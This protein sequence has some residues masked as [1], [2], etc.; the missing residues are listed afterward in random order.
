MDFSVVFGLFQAL[1]ENP[2]QEMNIQNSH[3]GWML[4]LSLT[5]SKAKL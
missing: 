3:K 4:V 2:H 1:N 5:N